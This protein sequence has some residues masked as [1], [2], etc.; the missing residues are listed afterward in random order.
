MNESLKERFF[1][2]TAKIKSMSGKVRREYIWDYYKVHIIATVALLL[3]TGS[4]LN[5]TVI[6]PPPRPVLTIA[7]LAG[8]EF[9]ETLNALSQSLYPYLVYDERRET[10]FV[11]TFFMGSGDPQHDMAMMQRF[12]A[13]LAAADLDVVI[14]TLEQPQSEDGFISLGG[15]APAWF[16]LD[17]RRFLDI[18]GVEANY[19]LYD[20]DEEGNTIAFA[21]SLE[22][23]PL[24]ER[25]GISSSGRYIAITANTH[26]DGAILETLRVLWAEN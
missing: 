23:N 7:W 11:P 4:I 10:V 26:R 5:D 1:A 25:L 21:A 19:L 2:E 20:T 24:F 3:M 22:G 8:W 18:A 13:M 16:F 17:I 6:N 9:E 15:L 14:G 12:Q